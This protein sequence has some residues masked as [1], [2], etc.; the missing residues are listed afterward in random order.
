MNLSFFW[1]G[2]GERKA[3]GRERRSREERKYMFGWGWGRQGDPSSSHCDWA[4]RAGQGGGPCRAVMLPAA[5]L[6]Q[7]PPLFR[8]P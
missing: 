3:K 2:E 5:G 6:P 8:R 1:G 4:P 7:R